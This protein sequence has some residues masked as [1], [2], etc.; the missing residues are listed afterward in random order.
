MALM[1]EEVRKLEDN[2][3]DRCP[4]VIEDSEVNLDGRL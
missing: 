3:A 1:Q 4:R 2:H